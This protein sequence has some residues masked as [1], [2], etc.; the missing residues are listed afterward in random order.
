MRFRF[1]V[2]VSLKDGLLDPQGKAVQQALPVLGWENV[3]DVRVGKYIDLV[4]DADDPGVALDQVRDMA[5]RFLANPV[6]EEVHI[7]LRKEAAG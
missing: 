3:T 5:D 6:I 1:D 2:L 7:E 4:V